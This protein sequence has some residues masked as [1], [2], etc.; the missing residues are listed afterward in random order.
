MSAPTNTLDRL[1]NVDFQ[2]LGEWI[3]NENRLSYLLAPDDSANRA[4][5][6]GAALYA[7]ACGEHVLYIGKTSVGQGQRF[8]G[9][10]RPAG[11]QSTNLKCSGN[12]RKLL[13]DNSKVFIYSLADNTFLQW[14]DFEINLAAG[15]ED[16]LISELDPPWN[17]RAGERP[18]TDSEM[19]ERQA[20]HLPENIPAAATV[21]EAAVSSAVPATEK[22]VGFTVTLGP[23][24]YFKGFINVPTDQS[25]ELGPQGAPLILFLGRDNPITVETKIDRKAN[26]NGSPRLYG[27]KK[28]ARWLQKY[29]HE[30]DT[31]HA[32]IVNENE[33]VLEPPQKIKAA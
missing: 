23:T 4:R 28:L 31:L 32:T 1:T 12:I 9:Y 18:M 15:L 27:G 26:L 19:S 14:G 25:G 8:T 22:N 5:L 20:L 3:L 6:K 30:S 11:D 16:S 17:G 29:F 21:P 7:F 2:L 13:Q 33:I 10:C 24:Y